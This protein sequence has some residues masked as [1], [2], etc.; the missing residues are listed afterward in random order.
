MC[1]GGRG[2]VEE[3]DR[4]SVIAT[5]SLELSFLVHFSNCIHPL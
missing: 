2:W 1:V 5:F 4:I 3:G